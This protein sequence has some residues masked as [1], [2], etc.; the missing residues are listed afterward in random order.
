[1][2][3]GSDMS[4]YGHCSSTEAK[5]TASILGAVAH[6]GITNHKHHYNANRRSVGCVPRC[7]LRTFAQWI[8]QLTIM[9]ILHVLSTKKTPAKRAG[10]TQTFTTK[11]LVMMAKSKEA[12]LHGMLDG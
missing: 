1:M 3:M 6:H 8:D 2:I 11:N 4:A 12:K 9:K 5:H 7:L 10:S